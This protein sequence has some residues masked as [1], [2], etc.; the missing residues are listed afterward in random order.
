MNN[1]YLYNQ[2]IEIEDLDEFKAGMLNLNGAK[3]KSSN[4]D[5]FLKSSRIYDEVS[6][7]MAICENWSQESDIIIKFIEQLTSIE[8]AISDEEDLNA[9]YPNDCNGFMGIDFEDISIS[10]ELQITD[11]DSFN[12]FKKRHF[13]RKKI[14]DKDE[15]D[16]ILDFL[17][18]DYSFEDRAIDDVTY[19]N[20]E[21]I[22][23][24]ERL[25]NVLEDVRENPFTGGIGKTEVLSHQKGKGVASKR[26]NGGDRLTYSLKDDAITILACKGHYT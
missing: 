14:V 10:P 13:I 18:P 24:Y 6:I 19:W 22:D 8:K 16:H 11:L 2:A 12:D 21:N 3:A 17:Y 26:I 15:L 25:H 20:E 9:L 1:F 4:F 23:M 5:E 7:L